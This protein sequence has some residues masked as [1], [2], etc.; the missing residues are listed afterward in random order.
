MNALL[1]AHNAVGAASRHA[2]GQGFAAAA[3]AKHHGAV[4]APDPGHRFAARSGRVRR[5]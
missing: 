3:D 1:Y 2:R 5:R 4:G